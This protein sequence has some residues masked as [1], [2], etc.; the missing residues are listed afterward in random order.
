[1]KR[2]E[3]VFD[4]L[5]QILMTFGFTILCMS[6][7]AILFGKSAR[8]FSSLFALG[9]QGLTLTTILQFLLTSAIITTLRF[10]FF[11]DGLIKR[12]SV[13]LRILCM[14]ALILVMMV[15]FILLFDWFPADEW[16]PWV[17]FFGCFGI[18]AVVSAVISGMKEKLENRLMEEALERLKAEQ[19]TTQRT[20]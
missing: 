13:T 8:G 10:L 4:F 12:L 6:I 17:M 7:F 16:M 3:T 19:D 15:A 1:M 11:T 20:Q 5:A 9:N 2:N 18:S 14:F